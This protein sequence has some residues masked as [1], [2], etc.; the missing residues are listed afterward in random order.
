MFLPVD[1]QGVRSRTLDGYFLFPVKQDLRDNPAKTE[2]FD[3]VA[4]GLMQP[5]LN[6]FLFGINFV[7]AQHVLDEHG[8]R[9]K[10]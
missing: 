6:P 8:D 5:P 9:P 10:G 3:P 7:K 4:A 1:D 2:I